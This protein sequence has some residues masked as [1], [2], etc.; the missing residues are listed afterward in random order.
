[1]TLR[2]ITLFGIVASI[3]TGIALGIL[4]L[5]H[6]T[7]DGDA[8]RQSRLIE[9]AAEYIQ[10]H[11]VEDLPDD[12]LVND[13]LGGMLDGL[14]EH[15][16]FLDRRAFERLQAEAEGEFGGIGVQLAL[17]GG[18]FTIL[19]PLD[20]TPAAQAGL[21]AGDRLIAIGGE[22]LR[23]RRLVEVVDLLRGPRQTPVQLTLLRSGKRLQ[24]TLTRA[25]IEM[26]SVDGRWL[27]PGFA[28]VRIA[29]FLKTTGN[30]FA[31]VIGVLQRQGAIDGL[32][33][34]LRGNPGGV[35]GASVDVADA[36]LAKGLLV[37][38][39]SRPESQ[40][41]AHRATVDDLLPGVPVA[42][43]IDADSASGSEIVAAALKDHGRAIVVGTRSF[44]KGTVQ[45]LLPL[46]DKRA[47]KLTTGYY[48]RPNGASIDA[49]GVVPDVELA[50]SGDEAA[51]AAA[52]KVLKD[53]ALAL[54]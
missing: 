11:Y 48:F 25:R 17:V 15:S 19:A 50:A 12:Q 41:L 24:H 5:R 33:L 53:Q 30:R 54:R 9:K 14:D 1:M 29:R 26:Q 37:C 23:G 46:A 34:D 36:L 21:A 3:V 16:R 38:T 43:L 32:I 40:P 51:F 27:E 31:G 22:S 6:W 2:F 7:G 39:E 4:G 44:G 49:Q 8:V 20:G 28:L 18:Y 45:S 47:L 52:L 35:L 13:A 10:S 42:V